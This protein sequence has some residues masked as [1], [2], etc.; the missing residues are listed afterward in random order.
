MR[1]LTR[2]FSLSG[3]CAQGMIVFEMWSLRSTPIERISF[4]SGSLTSLAVTWGRSMSTPVFIIGAVIM[5]MIRRTSI[6]STSGVTLISAFRSSLPPVLIAMG[7]AS[8][9]EVT[10]DDVQ[11]VV[12]EGLHLGAQDADRPHEVVVRHHGRDR[13]DQADRGGEQRLR[14]VR[15]DDLERCGGLGVRD[16]EEREQDA[17]HGAE[18]ADER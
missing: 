1:F 2:A 11:V 14:D 6:T 13:R 3:S 4:P 10:L 18:Q 15:A 5:K 8:A 7:H 16:L 17:D 9:K 12:L